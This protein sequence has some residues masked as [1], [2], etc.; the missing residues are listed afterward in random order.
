M[1]SSPRDRTLRDW[2]YIKRQAI[3]SPLKRQRSPVDDHVTCS[4]NWFG[5]L[6]NRRS[7]RRRISAKRWSKRRLAPADGW[8][9]CKSG[10]RCPNYADKR[11]RAPRCPPWRRSQNVRASCEWRAMNCTA[12]QRQWRSENR[13]VG[14]ENEPHLALLISYGVGLKSCSLSKDSLRKRF[15]CLFYDSY[16]Y[17]ESAN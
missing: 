13:Q 16:Q 11:R 14:R 3:P 9:S 10:A 15:S 12:P 5:T 6:W 2:I 7:L 8:D 4:P 17:H 1:Q